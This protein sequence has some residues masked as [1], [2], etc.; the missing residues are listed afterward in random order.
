MPEGD[1]I[2]R[3]ARTLQRALGG[4]VVTGFRSML[5][6]LT[7]DFEHFVVRL[8]RRSLQGLKIDGGS[9]AGED[10]AR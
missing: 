3:S 2:Y 8:D 1:T 9:L 6:R 4:K 10:Q 5:P 7:R